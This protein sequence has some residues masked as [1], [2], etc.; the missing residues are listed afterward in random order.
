MKKVLPAIFAMAICVQACAQTKPAA[1]LDSNNTATNLGIKFSEQKLIA[2]SYSD[3]AVDKLNNI[4]LLTTESRQ[5][6]KLDKNADSC[7]VFNEVKNFGNPSSINVANPLKPLVF[8]KDY[9][10]VVMLDR[11]LAQRNIVNLRRQNIFSALAVAPSYD[12]NLWVYDAQQMKLKK[13]SDQGA[14]LFETADMRQILD[15]APEPIAI[16][17]S[18]NAV[19]LYDPE[20]GFF[21]FDYY[22]AFIK[23]LP[24]KGWKDVSVN[25]N[26]MYGFAD[27][28]LQAYESKTLKLDTFPFALKETDK[29]VL[30]VNNN[31]FLLNETG[32]HVFSLN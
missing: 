3:M 22:G 7:C 8:F 6:K 14:L 12:D 26:L 30:V 25:G 31:V 24:F 5:L 13:I 19:Y 23:S 21:I 32:V 10:T 2:G 11:F 17:D 16:F 15:E 9:A 29:K 20:K 18:E 27:G 1:S 28:K 4:Y